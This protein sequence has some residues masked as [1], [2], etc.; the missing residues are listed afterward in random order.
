MVNLVKSSGINVRFSCEDSFRSNIDDILRVYKAI[1]AA[2]A[3]R[4]YY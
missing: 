3:N 1:V 2:G 4:I